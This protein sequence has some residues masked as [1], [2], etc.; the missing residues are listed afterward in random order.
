M[1]RVPNDMSRRERVPP[2]PGSGGGHG[3]GPTDVPPG[4]G[5]GGP[6]RQPPWD[7]PPEAETGASFGDW[8]RRQREMREIS[9]RDIADRSD[10][11]ARAGYEEVPETWAGWLEALRALD[12]IMGD[13]GYPLIMPTNDWPPPFILGSKREDPKAGR[14][15][16]HLKTGLRKKR[17]FC[18]AWV[19][20]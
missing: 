3:T 1:P 19:A 18:A 10:L 14:A 13:D 20:P 16:E 6:R 7:K 15:A 11:L 9:L 5:A 12:E 2:R 17:I 8:L 4:G